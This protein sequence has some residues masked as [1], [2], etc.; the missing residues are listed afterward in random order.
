MKDIQIETLHIGYPQHK[1]G[2]GFFF[3]EQ[4]EA[5]NYFVKSDK[6]RLQ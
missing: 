5:K 1:N 6:K 3:Q 4:A 2:S